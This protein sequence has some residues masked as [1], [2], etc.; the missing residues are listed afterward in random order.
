MLRWVSRA[1]LVAA[2]MPCTDSFDFTMD[3]SDR[4]VR[5]I[6][7]CTDAFTIAMGESHRPVRGID[8]MYGFV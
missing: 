4:A 1:G 7:Q 8:A 6:E 3:E 5:G 2:S